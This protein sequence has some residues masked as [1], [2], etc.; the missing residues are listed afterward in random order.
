MN[1]FNNLT[2]RTKLIVFVGLMLLA[3]A[4]SGFNAI[5]GFISWSEGMRNFSE[6][7]LPS[8]VS[9]GVLNTERMDIRAQ[10][11]SV[12]RES[13][14]ETSAAALK[15]IQAARNKSWQVV[16]QYWR[17]FSSI[18]KQSAEGAKTFKRLQKEY[19]AWREIYVELDGL[20]EQMIQADSQTQLNQ[21]LRQY[22]DA[23]E[24]MIPISNTM[25]KTFVAITKRSEKTGLMQASAAV[26][27]A[28]SKSFTMGIIL[29]IAMLAAVLVGAYMVRAITRPLNNMVKTLKNI[30]QTGDFSLKV[31]HNAQ[32]E[33]GDAAMAVNRLM[34]NLQNALG[35]TND[36]VSALSKG[37]FSQRIHGDYAGDLSTL[38]AGVNESADSISETMQQLSKVMHALR[39]GEFR[40]KVNTQLPG[41]FGD[42]MQSVADTTQSL[43]Q[44]ISEVVRVMEN[45]RDGQFDDRVQAPAKGDLEALKQMINES[46]S[47]LSQAIE[48][49]TSITVGQSNGDLTRTI[50]AHYPGEL[51][52]LKDA[53]NRSVTRLEEIV[54]VAAVAANTVKTA[55]TE[56]SQGSLDLSERVQQQAASIEESSAT[57]EEFSSAVQNNAQNATQATEVEKQVESKALEA[58]EVMK[59]TIEAM[60]AIQ[61]SSHKIADIVTLI[62][63]IA[64]QTNLLALNAAVEAA[65]A[66]EH[67]RGFAVVAGEV[68]ALAQKS[69]D[70]AKD[71]TA[72]INESVSRI[73]QGTHLATQSGEVIQD[74]TRSIESVT[75][76]SAEISQASSEQAEGVKQ[77]QIAFTDIDQATQQNAALVEQTSAAAESMQEQ[78]EELSRQM[79]FFTTNRKMNAQ[80]KVST[81]AQAPTRAL[82]PAQ[83]ASTPSTTRDQ[84]NHSKPSLTKAT[85]TPKIET[86]KPNGKESDEWSDF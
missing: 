56:V 30:D 31:D 26:E 43:N 39:N 16:D 38:Q 46:M 6:V 51:G 69:A 61:E 11:I 85:T 63:G 21:L 73:D 40:V 48:D 54:S 77:L 81:V 35:N 1:W 52:V 36:V 14:I 24:R 27:T 80:D 15:N 66:G 25:G 75:K 12:F 28:E 84:S 19:Q 76:M 20:I 83:I 5:R 86:F 33:V 53:I 22:D 67:G 8:V 37:D 29:L 4:F 2:I 9:L 55:S 78:A 59:E 82:A 65:R 45:M 49:I 44:S 3:L 60:S 64:F 13:D 47:A 7:R 79:A 34:K 42:M 18:P 71:I 50:T 10:T 41:E 68:R 32:D 72:L 62:D 70:A 23:V 58:S 57:M 74:I 17:D